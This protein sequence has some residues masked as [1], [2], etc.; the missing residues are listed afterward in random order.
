MKHPR[1]WR[2]IL[3]RGGLTLVFAAIAVA[4]LGADPWI[5]L[6]PVGVTLLVVLQYALG[7]G[8]ESPSESDDEPR[9]HA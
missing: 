3:I 7:P 9:R 6:V 8:D 5:W 4:F 2:E 1:L